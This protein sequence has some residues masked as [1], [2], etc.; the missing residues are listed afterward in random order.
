[1]RVL[2]YPADEHGCGHHR[3]IWPCS[4]VDDPNVDVEIVKPSDRR[5][6]VTVDSRTHQAVDVDV[7][8]GVDVVVLQRVT[9]KLLVSVIEV[10]RSRGIAVVVDIDDDL[11]AIHP[12]NVAFQALH[13]RNN[14]PDSQ[15]RPNQ[16][17]WQNLND[18]CRQATLVTVSTPGLLPIYAKHGR[19][20]VLNNYLADHYYDVP[21]ED[22]VVVGWPG[23]I[24]T[25]PDDPDA[26][27]GA[28]ARLVEAGVDFRVVGDATDVDRAF[29]LPRRPQDTGLVDLT[30]W[31]AAI[32]KLG[33]A[34]APLSDSR[35]N[36]SKS[37][38]KPLECA[39]VGVPWVGSPLAEYRRLAELG[40][41]MLAAKPKD[42]Y[43]ALR[44]LVD[45]AGMRAD[46]SAMGRE[47]AAQLRLRDH[48]WR[49]AEAFDRAYA[50]EHH[51]SR[52]G[53]ISIG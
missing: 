27:G 17:S 35:F 51:P 26:V 10:L 49:W 2:V 47:V 21:H 39:A 1:M 50:I 5:L 19:G 34:I 23:S 33:I 16:H 43:R 3:L 31:P 20:M 53:R 37:W 52:T 32:A 9:H 29:N 42:W 24:A 4:Y 44:R 28:L 15:G 45:D 46:H 36:R 41:G 38:L 25:H 30:S 12:A 14:I 8:D 18:A 7:P 48:A 40:C 13:P 6:A 11:K 22:S